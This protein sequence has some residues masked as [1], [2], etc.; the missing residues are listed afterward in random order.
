[1]DDLQFE[2][3]DLGGD[4][5]V[6]IENGERIFDTFDDNLVVNPKIWNTLESIFGDELE[7]FMVDWFNDRMDM[8]VS[9]AEPS[10]DI[11][12]PSGDDD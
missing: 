4:L 7:N 6:Y 10:W 5:T 9:T 2:I 3:N 12:D 1:M 11:Y 8:S